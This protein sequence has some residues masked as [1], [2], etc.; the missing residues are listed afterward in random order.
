M[1]SIFYLV[2]SDCPFGFRGFVQLFFGL[3]VYGVFAQLEL[4]GFGA[5]VQVEGDVVGLAVGFVCEA[6]GE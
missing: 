3:E 2:Q 6:L 4:T 1:L 5:E